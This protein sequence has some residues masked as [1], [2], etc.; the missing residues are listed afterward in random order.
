MSI[1]LSFHCLSGS[2]FLLLLPDLKPQLDQD[3][4]GLDEPTFELGHV[5]EK[6]FDV[7]L[8]CVAHDAL[9]TG[10]I[11]PA[12]IEDHDFAAGRKMF[13]ITLQE[14]LCPVT[15]GRRAQRDDAEGSQ[16]DSFRHP[17][18][19]AA[20]AGRVAAFENDDDSCPAFANPVL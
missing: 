18:N 16:T 19:Q 14:E 17:P 5:L 1:G 20:L 4:A 6:P 2:S 10:A 3:D 15:F 11:V 8:F 12:A 9:D 13:D 7:F